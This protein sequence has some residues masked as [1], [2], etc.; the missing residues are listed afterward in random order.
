[1]WLDG[2]N[3][4]VLD[5]G[6][7]GLVLVDTGAPMLFHPH[8]LRRAVENTGW[9]I[10]DVSDI[11]ITHQHI[12]HAGG[13]RRLAEWTGAR[14]HVHPADAPEI[15]GGVA[16]RPGVGRSTL[17]RIVGRA[18]RLRAVGPAR[19]DAYLVDGEHLEIGIDVVHTPGHTDGHCVFLWPAHGGVLFCGDAMANFRGR[20]GHPPVAEDWDMA[21]ESIRRIAGLDFSIVAFGHGPVLRGEATSIVRGFAAAL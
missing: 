2:V 8:R 1:M 13:L 15:A 10:T 6:G 18:A 12:D 21:H 20:I 5:T 11:L 19:V 9:S 16:A 17:T 3:A 14:V 4:Y 7:D